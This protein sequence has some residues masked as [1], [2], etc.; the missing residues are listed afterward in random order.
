[1][2]AP[3]AWRVESILSYLIYSGAPILLLIVCVVH[4][5]RTGR[6]F[7]WI[8]IIVF[9]PLIGSLIY[10][11]MEILPEFIGSRRA[12]RLGASVRE[13]AD[14]HRGLREAHRTAGFVGSVDSKRTLAEEYM[15]RGR[16]AD[17][18]TVYSDALQGQFKD[19]TALL[20]G[21][22]R[23]QFLC[24]D[25]AATQLSLDAIQ[26]ADP[27]YASA[28]AHL[29][30]A[31]AL[32]LQEKDSE[33]LEEYRK[34]VRYYPG[35]EARARF[36]LLLKKLGRVDEAKPI[37]QEILHLLDGAP[38]RY[39]RAQKEWGDIAKQNSG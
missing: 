6:I 12:R 23:A 30:Y 21:L 34:L 17:A 18:R 38:A 11:G 29:L 3:V 13:L 32:E 26:A 25:G 8:Y 4:A 39:R 10:I 31:R 7:P 27:N 19:D 33:A 28:D 14:P 37:F 20:Y 5:I 15:A 9:L 2:G 22:A 24:G 36:G 16:Y 35:E 1:M